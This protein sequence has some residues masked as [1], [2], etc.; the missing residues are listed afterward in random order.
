MISS[1]ANRA[2]PSAPTLADPALASQRSSQL[3][4]A[5]AMFGRRATMLT[6]GQGTATPPQVARKTLLGGG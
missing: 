4:S 2:A 6:G 1:P 5:A 3:A